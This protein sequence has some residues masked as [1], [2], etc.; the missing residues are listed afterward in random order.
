MIGLAGG[1]STM[2]PKPR[3]AATGASPARNAL[4]SIPALKVPA[5]PV[6]T[7]TRTSA[8]PVELL[9]G[10]GDAA[11]D[12]A[13]DGVARLGTVDGDDAGTVS[14]LG[15]HWFSHV[16]SCA[17]VSYFGWNLIPPSKRMVSA[18]M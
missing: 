14:H 6:S 12:R 10:G 3:S 7:R 13:V 4:R 1:R 5:A 8:P 18:F 16:V 17:Q 15:Q 11:R 2:P 9:Q